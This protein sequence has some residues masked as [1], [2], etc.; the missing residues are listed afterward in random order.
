MIT[1]VCGFGRCG[2]SLVMQMLDVA[3]LRCAGFYPAFEV[4]HPLRATF[5]HDAIKWL[6]PQP[7]DGIV[8][9]E[10]RAVWL[11]RNA[12][13]QAQSVSK[14]LKAASRP[15]SPKSER[16]YREAF[17]EDRP[18]SLAYVRR[19]TLDHVLVMRFEDLIARPLES[20]QQLAVFVGQG[21]PEKMAAVVMDRGPECLPGLL[22]EEL[23][24]RGKRDGRL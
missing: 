15:I 3:G 13:Q 14:F 17:G 23:A 11:D 24:K 16:G 1:F 5:D 8:P 12:K 10:C 9:R 19:A 21:D 18:T 20:A 4:E 6:N 22:E 2:S 7:G